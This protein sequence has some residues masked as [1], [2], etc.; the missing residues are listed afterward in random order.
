LTAF[1]RAATV[2]KAGGV[3]NGFFT[4]S[5]DPFQIA[6]GMPGYSLTKTQERLS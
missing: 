4:L 6:S 2:A 1:W 3:R 5:C